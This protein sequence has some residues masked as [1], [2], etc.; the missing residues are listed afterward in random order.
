MP[1]ENEQHRADKLV[2]RIWGEVLAPALTTLIG[3]ITLFAVA[4]ANWNENRATAWAL[5]I[6]GALL[7]VVGVAYFIFVSRMRRARRH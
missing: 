7:I 2:Q 3:A 5:L 1:T 6:V 4:P